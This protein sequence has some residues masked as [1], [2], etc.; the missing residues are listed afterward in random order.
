[1]FIS[2]VVKE[3][4]ILDG[5][6]VVRT[7]PVDFF[8]FGYDESILRQRPELIALRVTFALQPLPEEQIRAVIQS[9]LDWRAERQPNLEA[10]PSCG[11][12]FKKIEGVGAGRLIEQVGLKG[13]QLGGA[14]VSEKHANFIV[15]RGGA[16][17][18]DVFALIELIQEKVE[19][20]TGYR[21]EPEINVVGER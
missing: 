19:K 5:E 10:F 16:T 6:G 9:N 4:E 17:A 13:F 20:G 21:L 7:V 12:V 8:G 11:S 14:Q 2:E 1:M 15:N 3:A 18:A